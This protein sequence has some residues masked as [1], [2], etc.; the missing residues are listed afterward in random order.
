VAPV[1]SITAQP[2]ALSNN[3]NPSFTFASNK[4]GTTY[5][6]ALDG[7]ALAAC[8]APQ[9]YTAL[10]SGAHTFT[11]QGIDT[12]GNS[13]SASYA[14]T[15]DTVAPSVPT[16]LSAKAASVSAISLSWTAATAS[17]GVAGYQTFT[18]TGLAASSTHSYTVVAVDAAG[19]AS[20]RSVAASATTLRPRATATQPT[21]T[22]RVPRGIISH[23]TAVVVQVRTRPGAD[24][25]ITLRLTRQGTRCTTVAHHRVC[26]PV[27][28]VLTQRVVHGR[29]NVQGLL[30]RSV[31]LGYS[32]ASALRATLGVQVSTSYGAVTHTT[33]VRLQPAPRARQR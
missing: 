8:T 27:T 20:A 6:C 10:A 30:T 15:I 31:A 9:A 12:A 28:V 33:A 14:F 2:P 32:P 5:Q 17:V 24:A 18:N 22:V 16:G 3:A 25:R 4:A 23:G 19:N 21:V 13:S 11:V 1:V 29:A 7:A 26:R